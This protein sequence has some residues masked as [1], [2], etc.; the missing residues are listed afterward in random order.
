MVRRRPR[1]ISSP[2]SSGMA[3]ASAEPGMCVPWL[4]ADASTSAAWIRPPGPLPCTLRRSMPC[5]R[6]MRRAAGVAR[7]RPSDDSPPCVDVAC[8]TS[9][10]VMRPAGPL[11]CTRARSMPAASAMRCATGLARWLRRVDGALASP[12]PPAG[13]VSPAACAVIDS[14][15][16]AIC[17]I[18]VVTGTTASG[19]KRTS[20][21]VPAAGASTSMSTLSVWTSRIGSPF[22][23]GSPLCFSQRMIV[24]SSCVMPNLGIITGTGMAHFASLTRR[25]AASTISSTCGTMRRSRSRL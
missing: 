9:C 12:L 2:E 23:T 8:A 25:R 7:T 13:G 15:A 19:P 5:S 20:K 10:L 22:S 1:S 6:P 18:S 3:A 11:P 17:A 4:L 21:I 14:P 24:P 16:T